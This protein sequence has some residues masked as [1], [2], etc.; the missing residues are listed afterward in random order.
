[1]SSSRAVSS[2]WLSS[3]GS[4]APSSGWLQA[5]QDQLPAKEPSLDTEGMQR[6]VQQLQ[7]LCDDWESQGARV[8]EL[9]KTGSE[10]ESTIIGITAPQTKTV[11]PQIN[12]SANPGSVNGIHTCKD[13]TELQVAVAEVNGR[14]ESLGSE[15]KERHGRQQAALELRQQA[16]QGAQ[17]L[18]SWL[19]DREHSLE[20]GHNASPSKPE[21]VR[22]KA[23]ENKALLRELTEHSGKVEELKASLT[24]LIADN[25]DSPEAASWRQQLQELDSRWQKAN[26]TAAQRQTE[27]ETCA[28]RLG[29]FATAASQLGPWLREKELMMSVLGPL[30]IDPN[31]LNTQKQQVQFMLR[32]FDTRRPQ[33]DELTQSAEGILSQSGD[34]PQDPKDLQEVRAELG[35][36][37]KQW[38]DLTS[39]LD[40][41]S[42]RIDRAQGTSE[43]YQALLKEL[44]ASVGDL[45]ERLDGQA[46]LSAQPEALRSRLQETGEVRSELELRRAELGEAERLCEELSAIVDEPYL[47]EELSKRLEA[48]GAPLRSLEERAA[49][50]QSPSSCRPRPPP[51]RSSRCSTSLRCWLDN[52]AGHQGRP[53]PTP[54]LPAGGAALPAAHA[55]D[56]QRGIAA[57]R[58]P[59]SPPGRGRLAAA[60]RLPRRRGTAPR[61]CS[62]ALSGLRQDWTADQRATDRQNRLKSTLAKAETYQ[63]PPGGAGALAGGVRGEGRGNTAVAG[64]RRPDGPCRGPRTLS[65]DL[66]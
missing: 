60:R 5:S 14:Y 43:R 16:S 37:S 34:A 44:A 9:N 30:S 55:E 26:E 36:I 62:R 20:Q 11:D 54:A 46:S 40:L 24:K 57:P 61:P 7:D 48:V 22:A 58:A 38:E 2:G 18:S 29:S 19:R 17:E 13:L 51:S 6:R 53:R 50:G 39:R 64:P 49:D 25:P 28:D 21:V 45:G 41:R 63:K 10:L 65:M 27:L 52:Q 35:S 3:V 66:D 32:E 42:G 8:Q 47:R 33:Y 1:M 12:G 15:L 23:Q 59:T 31:M 56:L 4:L